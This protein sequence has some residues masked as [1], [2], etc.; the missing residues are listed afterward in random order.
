MTEGQTLMK[1]HRQTYMVS[2]GG[3]AVTQ[4]RRLDLF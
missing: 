1:K 2:E 4:D 3:G